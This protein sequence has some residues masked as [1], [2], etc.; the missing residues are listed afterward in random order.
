MVMRPLSTCLCVLAVAA[1]GALAQGPVLYLSHTDQQGKRVRL[2]ADPI[3]VP[4][5]QRIPLDVCLD[6]GG[7]RQPIEQLE[8]QAVNQHPDYFKNRPPA[9]ITLVVRRLTQQ[10]ARDV[11]FTI[12]SSGGGQDLSLHYRNADLDIIADTAVRE[13]KFREFAS[14]IMARAV[15][16]PSAT[17]DAVARLTRPGTIDNFVRYF[18]ASNMAYIAPGEYEIT[19]FYAPTTPDHWRGRVVSRPIRITVF[20]APYPMPR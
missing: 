13:A 4:G 15:Q 19:A 16:E 14:S 20:D 3:R 12:T 18:E 8:V 11:S 17:P 6:A 10:G 9:N 7:V 2:G 1:S 5:N